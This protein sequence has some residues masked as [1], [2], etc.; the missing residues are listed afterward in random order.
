MAELAHPLRR[1]AEQ[2]A[3]PTSS[4]S[5]CASSSSAP[6]AR[7]SRQARAGAPRF[8]ARSRRAAR[9]A[10]GADQR[11]TSA[12][13]E[14]ISRRPAVRAD[15]V[16]PRLVQVEQGGVGTDV[17]ELHVLHDWSP[18]MARIVV[19]FRGVSGKQRLATSDEVRSTLALAMLGDVLTACVACGRTLVV[20]DDADAR[21]LRSSSASSR[22]RSGG[23]QGLLSLP[24]STREDGPVVVVNADSPCV[25][26]TTSA[27]SPVPPSSGRWARRGRGR[28]T[29]ALALPR[30][31]LFAPLY[32]ARS[33]DR[34]RDHLQAHGVAT[35]PA[36][37]GRTVLAHR[38]LG[39]G[40][41][42]DVRERL[43]R[44]HVLRPMLETLHGHRD[45][46]ADASRAADVDLELAF[47]SDPDRWA[48]LG[49]HGARTRRKA[50]QAL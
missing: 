13:V 2:A 15:G 11:A 33:A 45:S 30:A 12:G 46:R 10:P 39:P 14:R 47:P 1:E 20:T 24:R 40:A 9:T 42:C 48:T 6:P 18:H 35:A 38:L 8:Q 23:G 28:T 32:G 5:V 41:A 3:T 44:H 19:P 31:S 37:E 50:R 21:A 4:G 36:L 26:R 49:G 16:V 22:R 25:V 17:G 27:R 43:R 7:L 29:N 34:F